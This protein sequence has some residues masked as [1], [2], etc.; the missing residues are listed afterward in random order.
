MRLTEVTPLAMSSKYISLKRDTL[1][2]FPKPSWLTD[3]FWQKAHL[4]V[5]PEKNTAPVP[6]LPLMQGSSS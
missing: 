1:T 6:V 2:V 3:Q 4:R 5:Q